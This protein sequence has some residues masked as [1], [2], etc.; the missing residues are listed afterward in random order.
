MNSLKDKAKKVIK[1][2]GK[3]KGKAIHKAEKVIGKAEDKAEELKQKII[4]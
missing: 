1:K 4:G 2:V 3:F